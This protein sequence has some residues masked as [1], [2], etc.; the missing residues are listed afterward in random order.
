MSAT[1]SQA[2]AAPGP[3]PV[4]AKGTFCMLRAKPRV[5]CENPK[6]CSSSCGRVLRVV[7]SRSR[8]RRSHVFNVLSSVPITPVHNMY[9]KLSVD[10][11]KGRQIEQTASEASDSS[12]E[13]DNYE[14]N[15]DMLES[16]DSDYEPEAP[17]LLQTS[18]H[19]D[20]ANIPDY[21]IDDDA[22]DESELEELPNQSASDSE[23]DEGENDDDDSEVELEDLGD[24]RNV[25]EMCVLDTMFG[26]RNGP[27]PNEVPVRKRKTKGIGRI[28]RMPQRERRVETLCEEVKEVK[29]E[30][31]VTGETI[32]DETTA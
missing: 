10:A 17:R 19:I 13:S 25:L 18:G 11:I 6:A 20:D 31:N 21:V 23:V 28:K 29:D 1:E 27:L 14:P 5:K 12:W 4:V 7:N 30:G 22:I 24:M 16:G 3:A 32:Q 2:A 8:A 26:R 15:A 9:D